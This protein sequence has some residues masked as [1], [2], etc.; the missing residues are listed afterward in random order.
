MTYYNL[1]IHHCFTYYS[2]TFQRKRMS[3]G[4]EI[5][6]WLKCVDIIE[7]SFLFLFPILWNII[8]P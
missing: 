1:F 4:I 6:G 7:F 5:L 2:L 3:R 8:I